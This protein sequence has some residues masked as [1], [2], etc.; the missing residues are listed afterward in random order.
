MPRLTPIHWKKFEKFLFHVGCH[1][2][3]QRGAHRKYGR[4]DL[5]RPVI[6]TT[7]KDGIIPKDHIK[8]NLFTLKIKLE[9][10]LRIIEML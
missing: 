4:P 2:I 7:S 1:F 5:T 3:L 9:D 6:I 10:Y 8:T